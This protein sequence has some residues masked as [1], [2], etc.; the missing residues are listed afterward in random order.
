M[1]ISVQFLAGRSAMPLRAA[2]SIVVFCAS[3]HRGSWAI[4]QSM[5]D[6]ARGE[7]TYPL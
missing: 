1:P 4:A 6:A 7:E 2:L 5:P 3:T